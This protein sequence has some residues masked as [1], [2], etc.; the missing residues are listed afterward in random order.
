MPHASYH[1][2]RHFNSFKNACEKM[3]FSRIQ[4]RSSGLLKG[5]TVLYF[6]R[7]Y[8][9][10]VNNYITKHYEEI[11]QVLLSRN[12]QLLYFPAIKKFNELDRNFIS[13]FG[14]IFPDL[15]LSGNSIEKEKIE[16]WIKDIDL[17]QLYAFFDSTLQI[18][19]LPLPGFIRCL[20]NDDQNSN[21]E[22]VDYSF[23][24]IWGKDEKS[25]KEE[26]DQY[27]SLVGVDSNKIFFNL[28]GPDDS[29]YDP[30]FCLIVMDHP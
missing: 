11:Q 8:E 9:P 27:L 30:D 6:E 19:D 26:V 1:P 22:L 18:P 17:T 23:F 25:V 3:I 20:K 14:Y 5:S 2:E 24:P 4:L 15:L 7:D 21:D 10:A 16:E 13:S 12:I 28:S 29:Q